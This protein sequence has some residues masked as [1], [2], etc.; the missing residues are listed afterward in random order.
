MR[1]YPLLILLSLLCFMVLTTSASPQSFKRTRAQ[2]FRGDAQAQY[3]LGVM[4]AEGRVVKQ[5]YTQAKVV[6]AKQGGNTIR[7]M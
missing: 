1:R 6:K 2:A 3:Q 4:Y 5:N 7:V